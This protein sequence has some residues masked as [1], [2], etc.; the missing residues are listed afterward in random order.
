MGLPAQAQREC[1]QPLVTRHPVEGGHHL[2]LHTGGP[3]IRKRLLH[4]RRGPAQADLA[5]PFLSGRLT[6]AQAGDA[7]CDCAKRWSLS[8][9]R[10]SSRLRHGQPFA[11]GYNAWHAILCNRRG[12]LA[13]A[14][15]DALPHHPSR[16]VLPDQRK[17]LNCHDVTHE[18]H[19]TVPLVM[20]PAST[21]PY[22]PNIVLPNIER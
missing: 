8:R 4:P 9:L 7:K 22:F 6:E 17:R 14:K 11:H 19:A 5:A 3:G 1:I 21:A 13:A 2:R 15:P 18:P 20:V 12:L 10:S 16:T